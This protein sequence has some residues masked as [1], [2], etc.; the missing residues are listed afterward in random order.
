MPAAA[1]DRASS[2][3][4]TRLHRPTPTPLALII[5]DVLECVAVVPVVLDGFVA[6]TL[7]QMNRAAPPANRRRPAPSST[8]QRLRLAFPR[9]TGNSASKCRCFGVTAIASTRYPLARIFATIARPVLPEGATGSRSPHPSH[10]PRGTAS[11]PHARLMRRVLVAAEEWMR[12]LRIGIR[13]GPRAASPPGTGLERIAP[14]P[15][16]SVF[17]RDAA[18]VGGRMVPRRWRTTG[19]LRS[20]L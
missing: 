9:L 11:A 17:R 19:A 2:P 20:H 14:K 4:G 5:P 7:A 13:A 12:C 15:C 6:A 18:G 10:A 16:R 1:V 8:S 3:H